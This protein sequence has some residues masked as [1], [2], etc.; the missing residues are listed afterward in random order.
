MKKRTDSNQQEII[1]A[2]REIGCSVQ[3]LSQVGRGTPDILVGFHNVNVLLEIK[4]CEGRAPRLTEP[5]NI[6][7]REWKGQVGVVTSVE[8]AIAI[9]M[10]LDY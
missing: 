7:I 10:D 6:W 1:N 5:E 9:L 2:L 3:D 8:D 4:F